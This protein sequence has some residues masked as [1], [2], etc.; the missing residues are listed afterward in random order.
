M[1]KRVKVHVGTLDEM[2][3][4]FTSAWHR[5]DHGERVR[6]RHVTF[7][8]LP[9]MLN[10]LSPKRLELLR[11]VHREPAASVKALAERLGRDYKRVHQDVETLTASGLL[12]RDRGRVCAPYDAITAEMRL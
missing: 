9:A 8:D 6:E 10:A 3:K 1:S 2:G 4:R 7:P 12:Q 11:D 5:L